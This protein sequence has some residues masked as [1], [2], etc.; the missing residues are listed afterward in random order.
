MEQKRAYHGLSDVSQ[1]HLC[2]LE[3]ILIYQDLAHRLHSCLL[4]RYYQHPHSIHHLGISK[5]L[6][7]CSHWCALIPYRRF[8]QA[9]VCQNHGHLGPSPGNVLDGR[10]LHHGYHH[11]GRLQQRHNLLRCPSFLL[12]GL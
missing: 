9:P 1:S 11:D 2:P 10:F 8:V 5:S 3:T 12:D 7:D 4:L 6:P